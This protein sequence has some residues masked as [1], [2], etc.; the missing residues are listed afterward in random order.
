VDTKKLAKATHDATVT[1]K[2]KTALARWL[3]VFIF[4]LAFYKLTKR[5]QVE[6]ISD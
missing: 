4:V 3:T 2:A 5:V 6:L 1:A